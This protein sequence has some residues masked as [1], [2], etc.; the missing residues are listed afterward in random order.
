MASDES[1]SLP[2]AGRLSGRLRALVARLLEGERSALTRLA[3]TAFL[4]RAASAVIAYVSQILMARWMGAFEFGIYVYV[5]TWAVMLGMLAPLG[6]GSAAQRFLPEYM[7]R[8]QHGML[9]GFLN[10]GRWLGLLDRHLLRPAR[11]RRDV[12][13]GEPCRRLL[14]RAVPARLRRAAALWRLRSAGRHRP[15]L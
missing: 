6:L 4:V 14:C 12:A 7:E 13:A 3:G 1:A 11:R 5:W 9:K 10:G 8:S 2:F 15:L